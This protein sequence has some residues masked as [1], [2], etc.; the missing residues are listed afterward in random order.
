MINEK[1]VIEYTDNISKLRGV[2]FVWKD[3]GKEDVGFIAQEV[4]EVFPQLVQNTR[5]GYKAITYDKMIPILL[6]YI[7]N[8]EN[9]VKY[10]EEC[11]SRRV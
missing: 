2:H 10:L 1:L 5:S 6:E 9:R 3:T 7:K 8:V 11:L 4:E